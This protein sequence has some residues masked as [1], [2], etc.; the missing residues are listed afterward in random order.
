VED[1]SGQATTFNNLGLVS[2]ALGKMPE[3][4][5]YYE[6]ALALCREKGDLAVEGVTLNNLGSAYHA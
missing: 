5:D 2:Y 1:S 4:L 6:Q 3:A